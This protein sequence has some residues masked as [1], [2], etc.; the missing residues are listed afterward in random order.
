MCL[1]DTAGG[2]CKPLI[3]SL[4]WGRQPESGIE[5]KHSLHGFAQLLRNPTDSILNLS[6]VN[7]PD[8]SKKFL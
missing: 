3:L 8:S 4:V 5:R 6:C 2:G 7:R 1:P